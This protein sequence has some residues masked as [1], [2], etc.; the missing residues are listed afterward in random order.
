MSYTFSTSS[1]FA[2]TENVNL[3]NSDIISQI[4]ESL[5]SIT[6][7]GD[8]LSIVF[9]SPLSTTSINVLSDIIKTRD[10]YQYPVVSQ[11]YVDANTNILKHTINGIPY[12]YFGNQTAEIIISQSTQGQYTSI[13]AAILDNNTINNIF[14]VYPGTYI[15]DNPIILPSGC[16]LL[17]I[18]TAANTTIVAAN[19]EHN[20]I[21]INIGC[22]IFGFT[23]Y[24][25]K[26]LG[27]RGI[28]FDGSSTGGQ[29]KFTVCG[30][31]FIYDCDIAVE[32]DGKNTIG[33][34]DTLF[35]DK[36]VIGAQTQ[37]LSK[38]IFCHS[39]GSFIGTTCYI[40]GIPGYF[41]IATGIHC[42][43]QSKISLSAA[44]AYFCTTGL[45]LDAGGIVE[46]TLLTLSGNSTS[47]YFGSNSPPIRISANSLAISDS[48]I[49]DMD[50]Q[51]LDANIEIYSSVMDDAKINNP[52]KLNMNVKYNA[53]KFGS[54]Y[55][56]ILGDMQIGSVSN[57]SKLS[58]GEGL[59]VNNGIVVFSNTNLESG[60]WIDNTVGASSYVAPEFNLFINTSVNN[61]LY[62]GSDTNIYGFKLWITVSTTE[63]VP[64]SNIVWEYWN[65][66][67]W[68]E[69]NV[70]QSFTDNPCYTYNNSFIS[71]VSKF[72]IRLGLTTVTPFVSKLLN[73]ANKKWVRLRIVTELPSIPTAEYIKLHANTCIINND[74]F[75]EYFGNGRIIKTLPLDY[76]PYT[77]TSFLQDQNLFITNILN[78]GGIK[79]KFIDGSSTKFGFCVNIPIDIDTSFPAKLNLAFI[80]DSN[81]SGNINWTLYYSTTNPMNN[82][83]LNSSDAPFDNSNVVTIEKITNI[84]SNQNNMDLREFINIDI[85]NISSFP[86]DG[87]EPILWIFLE[88][89]ADISNTNDTYDGSVSLSLLKMTYVSWN[90]GGHIIGF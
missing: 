20:L 5:I 12:T 45:S 70:M 26:L 15:E 57:P 1:N 84:N 67:S 41:S 53:Q 38:G 65:G 46:L 76:T 31:C 42:E 63:I 69:F 18:G 2:T 87:H 83:Y 74:G 48:I 9:M 32:S 33:M 36:L 43:T 27:S 75:I 60:T 66:N 37:S 72:N 11:A 81:I 23:L 90:N 16:S 86:S 44:S 13:K 88:R 40:F 58:I 49:Y 52:N 21:I 55:Q 79:N 80:C 89:N 4:P 62:L 30:E 6:P 61:C 22:K 25:A 54:Y 17:A 39:K 64:L 28:Y 51:A 34:A 47:V 85:H 77:S 29:G 71:V 50:V 7:I 14:V 10:N 78:I 8:S 3:I 59:Y 35:C 56:A 24:G 82:I 19:P 68:I 73:G